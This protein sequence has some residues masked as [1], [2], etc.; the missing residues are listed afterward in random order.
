MTMY[1]Y[2]FGVLYRNVYCVFNTSSAY[3]T[4]FC[5]F[6]INGDVFVNTGQKLV[7]TLPCLIV[8]QKL[9]SRNDLE[10]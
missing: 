6:F 9:T 4:F 7:S 3:L 2:L 8:S 1:C 5:L 10:S